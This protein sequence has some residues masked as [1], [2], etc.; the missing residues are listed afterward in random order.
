MQTRWGLPPL[1]RRRVGF[2]ANTENCEYAVPVEVGSTVLLLRLITTMARDYEVT[3]TVL[4]RHDVHYRCPKCG[5]RLKSPLSDAGTTDSCPDCGTRFVVPGADDR[6]SIS[7][8]KQAAVEE[9][10]QQ[11]SAKKPPADSETK[12]V[13]KW[14][15]FRAAMPFKFIRDKW[16]AWRAERERIR[17][18]AEAAATAAV[19]RAYHESR[20]MDDVS[21]MS[22]TQFEEF[23][24][25]LL[26]RM[27]YTEIKLT[28]PNDQGGDLLCISPSGV[29]VVVQ[30]KRWKGSVGNSAVQELLGAMRHF[31]CS[32]GVVVTNSTFTRAAIQLAESDCD[33]TL[34]DKRWLEA[35]IRKYFPPDVPEFNQE[36][37]DR[38]IEELCELTGGI[39]AMGSGKPRRRGTPQDF[40]F[41]GM[42]KSLAE[43]K[44]KEL[45]PEQIMKTAQH[46]VRLAELEAQLRELEEKKS[47][48]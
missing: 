7:H 14:G 8:K 44:G 32:T 24:A 12:T 45:T 9:R 11:R 13:V 43:A 41:I 31:H 5:E 25:H 1:P 46:A 33:V 10:T 16:N 19:W 47:A 48:E 30:A 17:K 34:C 18:E 21:R 37:F 35:Q 15:F 29:P 27:G 3:K 6:Q 22:G 28:P 23:L 20:T 42:L 39:A 40:T 2:V 26:L 38:I 4:G 36:E